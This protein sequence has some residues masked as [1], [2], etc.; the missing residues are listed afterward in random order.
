MAKLSD[1]EK[2]KLEKERITLL[3]GISAEKSLLGK[4]LAAKLKR[5]KQLEE[6]L[7]F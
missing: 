5:K 3:K 2:K 1:T 7:N 4:A 6:A